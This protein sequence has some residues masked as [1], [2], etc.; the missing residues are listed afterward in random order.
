[1]RVVKNLSESRIGFYEDEKGISHWVNTVKNEEWEYFRKILTGQPSGTNVSCTKYGAPIEYS[2]NGDTHTLSHQFYRSQGQIFAVSNDKSHLIRQ[3]EGEQEGITSIE[4][5]IATCQLVDKPNDTKLPNLH[6]D[7]V[8]SLRHH[9]I[10]INGVIYA[11]S[12]PGWNIIGGTAKLKMAV[13]ERGE[14]FAIKIP[15]HYFPQMNKASSRV[16]YQKFYENEA[17][18]SDVTKL[19]VAKYFK[20]YFSNIDL[21]IMLFPAYE[22]DFHAY[23]HALANRLNNDRLPLSHLN[24]SL[25]KIYTVVLKAAVQLEQVHRA[26]ILHRD[27][28]PENIGIYANLNVQLA[29]FANA[30]QM[31]VTGSDLDNGFMLTKEYAAP[32]LLLSLD[33]KITKKYSFASDVYALAETLLRCSLLQHG[34]VNSISPSLENQ[35]IFRSTRSPIPGNRIHLSYFQLFIMSEIKKLR[36]D[37]LFPIELLQ[38]STS[39]GS[40]ESIHFIMCLLEK[41]YEISPTEFADEYWIKIISLVDTILADEDDFIQEYSIER[42]KKINRIVQ[43]NVTN[44][45]HLPYLNIFLTSLIEKLSNPI[46]YADLPYRS[47][48]AYPISLKSKDA[49]KFIIQVSQIPYQVSDDDPGFLKVFSWFKPFIELLENNLRSEDEPTR[50]MAKFI[51]N[52]LFDAPIYG[53]CYNKLELVYKLY[54]TKMPVALLNELIFNKSIFSISHE[55]VLKL[56]QWIDTSTSLSAD[57]VDV[58]ERPNTGKTAVLS[59]EQMSE[60]RRWIQVKNSKLHAVAAVGFEEKDKE[61][62]SSLTKDIDDEI[63]PL[64]SDFIFVSSPVKQLVAAQPEVSSRHEPNEA[65]PHGFFATF[66]AEAWSW[67]PVTEPC[68]CQ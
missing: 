21:P 57:S 19:L 30:T 27:I 24:E 49:E 26:R 4:W 22:K 5:E 20:R 54:L 41:F 11:Y 48:N 2:H 58:Q 31:D 52:D 3:G 65:N 60:I 40:P 10:I 55:N 18:V 39:L 42:F 43:F 6:K 66:K 50:K 23:S 45:I 16:K 62:S 1:M 28:K 17:A 44:A 33:S 29:G 53:F 8:D 36:Q 12:G 25:Q 9:A 61:A 7:W 47:Y 13:N 68:V 35:L 59:E 67:L 56:H 14:F 32:E 64:H 38:F 37:K 63:Q 34:A 15:H 51:L 46:A